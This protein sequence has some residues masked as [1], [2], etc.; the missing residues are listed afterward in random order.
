MSRAKLAVLV[1]TLLVLSYG[2]WAFTHAVLAAGGTELNLVPDYIIQK[3]GMTGLLIYKM[4]AAAWIAAYCLYNK[5]YKLLIVAV[6]I[7][8]GVCIWMAVQYVRALSALHQ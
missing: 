6:W 5:R 1:G 4:L 3:H 7:Y 8:G 2:D